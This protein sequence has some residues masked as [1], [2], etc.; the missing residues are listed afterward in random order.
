MSEPGLGPFES[1][2]PLEIYRHV[3]SDGVE[4]VDGDVLPPFTRRLAE[5]IA[6]TKPKWASFS[7][8]TIGPEVLS[9]NHSV[10]EIAWTLNFRDRVSV[11]QD[12]HYTWEGKTIGAASFPH[13]ELF[14]EFGDDFHSPEEVRRIAN[15]LLDAAKLL[16]SLQEDASNF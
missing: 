9:V 2:F 5:T 15:S 8:T 10:I 6:S 4:L 13:V 12:I 11:C 16:D 3:S 7:D 14:T 1:S